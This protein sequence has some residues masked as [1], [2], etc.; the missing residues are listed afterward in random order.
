MGSPSFSHRKRCVSAKSPSA[1]KYCP[2]ICKVTLG[3]LVSL[4]SMTRTATSLATG[5]ALSVPPPLLLSPSRPSSP[6]LHPIKL[7]VVSIR[8]HNDGFI[9]II[10]LPHYSLPRALPE[11]QNVSPLVDSE[12]ALLSSH[13]WLLES[14]RLSLQR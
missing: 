13:Y 6:L 5:A 7:N 11:P 8:A 2:E 9:F 1:S 3:V 14:F 4:P 12:L 10:L